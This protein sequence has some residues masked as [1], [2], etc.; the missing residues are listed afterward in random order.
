MHCVQFCCCCFCCFI[1]NCQSYLSLGIMSHCLF[2]N[3][4]QELGPWIQ[5]P[6]KTVDAHGFKSSVAKSRIHGCNMSKWEE[7][8]HRVPQ[9]FGPICVGKWTETVFFGKFVVHTYDP[10]SCEK[11]LHIF[12]LKKNDCHICREIYQT[13]GQLGYPVL[14]VSVQ[15]LVLNSVILSILGE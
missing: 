8:L 9:Y 1:T 4:A 12:F 2:R 10:W 3:S 7:F 6:E 14:H 13:F 11:F 5:T 15:S